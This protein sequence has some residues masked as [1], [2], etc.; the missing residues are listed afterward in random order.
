MYKTLIDCGQLQEVM[1]ATDAVVLDCRFDLADTG[2]GRRAYEAGHIPGAQYVH[3][4][5]D[6]SGPKLP[7]HG[8]H[9]LPAADRLCEI[10]GRLGIGPTGQVVVYD[11]MGGMLAAAR[12]WWLL[13]YLGYEAVAVLDGGVPAWTAAGLPVRS[14]TETRAPVAFS[15]QPGARKI[16][17]AAAVPTM[18]RLVDARDPA[19]FRGEAEPIDPVAGHIPGAVNHFCKNNLDSSA[20]FKPV[21]ELRALLGPAFGTTAAG[22][23]VFYCGSG[24]TAC[25]NVLAAVHAGY[26]EPL[27]YA[28]SWSEWCSDPS[29]AV[30][31]G[32]AG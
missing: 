24:V 23:T 19:R 7:G 25:H 16:V 15:G 18:P 6:L 30:A 20:R 2:A 31:R 28:G 8:R 17:A 4:D 26:D 10:F 29:R 1:C 5:E 11:A 14:G 21:A 12:A 27:L 9:P 22:Q 13:R 32:A 3:L